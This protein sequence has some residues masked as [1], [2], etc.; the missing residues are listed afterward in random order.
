[1]Q[2]WSL[3]GIPLGFAFALWRTKGDNVV[4][5]FIGLCLGLLAGTVLGPLTVLLFWEAYNRDKGKHSFIQF[6]K[7]N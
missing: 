2:Y 5:Q 1:M 4:I 7:N 3:I 6:K